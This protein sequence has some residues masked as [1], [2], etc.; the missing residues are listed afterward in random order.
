MG[1]ER[2]G[3][4]VVLRHLASGGMADVLLARTDGIEGFERHIILKRIRAEHAKDQRFITM[5]LDEARTAANL[6]HQ[7]IVQVFDIGENA[8]EYFFAMEY[9]HGEDLRNILSAVARSRTHMPLG[10]VVAIVAS[11]AAGLHYAHE[12]RGSD[13]KPMG[14]VHRDVS[15]SNVLIGY[16][17]SIK[18][19]DFGIAKAASTAETRSGSLKGKVAYMSPEQCKGD[20]IDR[21]SDVYALGVVLYELAT[22]TRLFKGDNDYLVMDSIVN[23]KV[24]LP[25][26]RRPDLPNE[27]AIII[28]RA[29][30][31]D[32]SK[33]Y[34]TAD[35]LRTALEQFASKAGLTAS[36]SAIAGYMFKLFGD[37]PEPWLA[38]SGTDV[39]SQPVDHEAATEAAKYSWTEVPRE[40][41]ATRDAAARAKTATPSEDAKTRTDS[42]RRRSGA[43]SPIAIADTI[44]PPMAQ[45]DLLQEPRTN[46]K[47]GWEKRP[48]HDVET[49]KRAAAKAVMFGLP[50][51]AI[52]G[53]ATWHFALRDS[54]NDAKGAPTPA[55]LATIT[56]AVAP[57]VVP[58]TPPPPVSAPTPPPPV[59][60]PTPRPPTPAPVAVVATPVPSSAAAPLAHKIVLPPPRK[61]AIKKDPVAQVAVPAPVAPAPA[62]VVVPVAPP[63]TPAPPPEPVIAQLS[64]ATIT[65]VASDHARQLSKCEGTEEVHGEVSVSFQIDAA[66]RVVKSQLSSSI[67]NSKVS[68]CILRS[69]QSWQ[70]PK[71][72]AGAAKGIYSLSFQ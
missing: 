24:P 49:R 68:G 62:P 2:L 18:V 70:F 57:P 59:S 36:T 16:D 30:S 71:P 69:V 56:P 3:R 19:V 45:P 48:T 6:H 7:N 53:I 17:G 34:Q 41:S 20:P 10:Y 9:I 51:L 61:T 33:R 37:K 66:G 8:G 22:T 58:I 44:A 35:E 13:K 28:M 38:G 54:G 26:V 67:K 42:K 50:M 29:L 64:D 25:R 12:R 39:D 11:A 40:D 43:L 23:G 55:P 5:F 32:L 4:Y 47:F 27:L 63:V 14:I 46:T 65:A 60:A 52:A 31:P 21:R 72:P 1:D 15:P